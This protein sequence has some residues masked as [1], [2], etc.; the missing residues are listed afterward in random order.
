MVNLNKLR[1]TLIITYLIIAIVNFLFFILIHWK[2]NE[3]AV[4]ANT[5]L[6][7]IMII[8]IAMIL[9]SVIL[10]ILNK[11]IFLNN[12]SSIALKLAFGLAISFAGPTIGSLLMI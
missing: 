11:N 9:L 8:N 7:F 4:Y 1:Q 10:F 5:S 12:T 2:T 3:L 6:I